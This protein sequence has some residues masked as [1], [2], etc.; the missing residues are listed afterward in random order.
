[1]TNTHPIIIFTEEHSQSEDVFLDTIVKW[2]QNRLYTDLH[3]RL[4]HRYTQLFIYISPAHTRDMQP[5]TA[6]TANSAD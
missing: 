1:M 4:T 2:L 6:H 3:T 5:K